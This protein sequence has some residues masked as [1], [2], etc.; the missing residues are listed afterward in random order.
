V[1]IPKPA[2][3]LTAEQGKWGFQL[4]GVA[5]EA[6][7]L[8]SHCFYGGP[9]KIPFVQQCG[10]SKLLLAQGL[11]YEFPCGS[12]AQEY[13]TVRRSR[14]RRS[15][16]SSDKTGFQA[17]SPDAEVASFCFAPLEH[18]TTLVGR[19]RGVLTVSWIRVWIKLKIDHLQSWP[20]YIFFLSP[21]LFSLHASTETSTNHISSQSNPEWANEAAVH[22]LHDLQKPSAPVP[23]LLDLMIDTWMQTRIWWS[24]MRPSLVTRGVT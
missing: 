14:N 8:I 10:I 21:L 3:V 4:D 20:L 5:R 11:E 7:C 1:R 2:L 15:L 13:G 16:H 9:F 24:M 19:L 12:Q 17:L 22:G 18:D 6:K 23:T